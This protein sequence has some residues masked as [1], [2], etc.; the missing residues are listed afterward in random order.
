MYLQWDQLP[1]VCRSRVLYQPQT[2]EII[3]GPAGLVLDHALEGFGREGIAR[4]MKRH[5]HAPAIGVTVT[6]M[7]A[8][9]RASEEAVSNEGADQLTGRQTAELAVVHRHGLN[10]DGD[11]RF[12][13]DLDVFG[14]RLTILD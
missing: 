9:L 13:G 1:F 12:L 3:L 10:G 11:Q 2:M 6:L 4:M 5:R 7:A 8:H 14:N